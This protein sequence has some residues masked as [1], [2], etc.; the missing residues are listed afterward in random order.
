M[1]TTI[2]WNNVTSVMDLGNAFSFQEASGQASDPVVV[3]SLGGIKQFLDIFIRDQLLLGPDPDCLS[4]R[5]GGGFVVQKFVNLCTQGSVGPDPVQ[6]DLARTS[7]GD[8]C[9][10]HAVITRVTRGTFRFSEWSRHCRLCHL[11]GGRCTRLRG[12]T[13]PNVCLAIWCHRPDEVPILV[14]EFVP[15]VIAFS[16]TTLDPGN[17]TPGLP[18]TGSSFNEDL[19]THVYVTWA[20]AIN[21]PRCRPR[22]GSLGGLL[23]WG[24]GLGCTLGYGTPEVLPNGIQNWTLFALPVLT[25]DAEF[26]GQA[27]P[28]WLGQWGQDAVEQVATLVLRGLDNLLPDPG[29]IR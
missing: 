21:A 16:A 7:F 20:N 4:H 10:S 8:K 13:T 3:T 25:L 29:G 14:E 28:L 24:R 23:H 22:H 27:T 6:L 2:Q 11:L 9:P 18:L 1:V 15:V 5:P 12:A 19:I 26:L 17:T